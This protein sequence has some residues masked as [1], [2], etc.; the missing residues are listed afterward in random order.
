MSKIWQRVLNSYPHLEEWDA[1]MRTWTMPG[2]DEV[3]LYDVYKFFIKEVRGNSLT[4]RSRAIAYSFFLSLFPA[5]LFVFSL[6]PYILSFYNPDEVNSFIAGLVK[7]VSPSPDVY[8]FLWGFISPLIREFSNKHPSVLT[9]TFLLTLYLTSNGVVAMMSSFDK[10]YD[11]Y[12]KRNTIMTRLVALKISILLVTLLICSMLLVVMGED[13]LQW[14]FKHL[15]IKN[16]F[17]KG[18]F[19]LVRYASIIMMFFFS[20]SFIYYYG[21]ATKK[22]YRFMSTGST[23]ATVLSILTSIAFSYYLSH[24]A[25]YNKIY[26]PIGTVIVIMIWLNLNAFVLLIGYEINAAIYY[27]GSLREL[28]EQAEALENSID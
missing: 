17:T 6:V 11:N 2:L 14:I 5:L 21:P 12:K 24:Y 26:G 10:T 28:N 19:S 15:Q 9:G 13:L 7:S 16:V 18:L 27:H 20:I 8:K 22:K 4:L 3:P 1:R 23:I 25:R